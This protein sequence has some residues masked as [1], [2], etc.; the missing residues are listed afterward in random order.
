MKIMPRNEID[1]NITGKTSTSVALY[2]VF[3][4]GKSLSLNSSVLYQPD[5]TFRRSITLTPLAQL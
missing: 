1:L 4:L 5:G 2:I 3:E